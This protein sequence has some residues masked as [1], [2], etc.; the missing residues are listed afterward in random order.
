M[1]SEGI[2]L[3]LPEITT[4]HLLNDNNSYRA[5]ERIGEYRLAKLAGNLT[6][7]WFCGDARLMATT[8]LGS[9][10]I[11]PIR[12]IA[13]A[14]QVDPFK[15]IASHE[16]SKQAIVLGHFDSTMQSGDGPLIGCGGLLER[17]KMDLTENF[18]RDT[19]H[20]YVKHHVDSPDVVFQTLKSAWRLTEFTN[21]PILAG[22]WDH[23]AYQ[24]TPIG[25]FDRGKRISETIIP[26]KDIV[27]NKVRDIN[28]KDIT[29]PLDLEGLLNEELS[30]LLAHNVQIGEHLAFDEAFRS[31]QKVQNPPLLMITTSVVPIPSRYPSLESP[32]TVFKI[33]LPFAKENNKPGQF[34]LSDKDLE[35][36]ISQSH[37]PISHTIKAG[38]GQAFSNTKTILIETPE[39][40]KSL[41]IANALRKRPWIQ[42]WEG[43]GGKIIIAKVKSGITQGAVELQ[44]IV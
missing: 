4:E 6:D 30:M 22:L 2:P 27:N 24:I 20:G 36:V 17:K 34:Y 5:R 15:Y 16:G 29:E 14:G 3:R 39:M 19:A 33:L 23:S 44:K 12:T 41:D 40:R 10:N 28:I 32:N 8:A 13:A 42:N 26:I 21:K 25:L 37:Y 1:M 11:R 9:R 18:A 35:F 7:V 43:Q 31:S 38:P